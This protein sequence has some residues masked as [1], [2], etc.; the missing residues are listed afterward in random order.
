MVSA[1]CAVFRAY[2]DGKSG[3][4]TCLHLPY[5]VEESERGGG[6]GWCVRAIVRR[7]HWFFCSPRFFLWAYGS[8]KSGRGSQVDLGR[9]IGI[10]VVVIVLAVTLFQLFPSSVWLT[11]RRESGRAVA[12]AYG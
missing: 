4:G 3:R 9:V 11:S 1:H 7:M 6:V 2:G 12:Q 8:G 5:F 10:S